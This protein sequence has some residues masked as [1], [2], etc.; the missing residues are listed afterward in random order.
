[1]IHLGIGVCCRIAVGY[2]GHQCTDVHI[3]ITRNISLVTTAIDIAGDVGT[4]NRSGVINN[5]I[6]RLTLHEFTIIVKDG[7]STCIHR[8]TVLIM[9]HDSNC[10]GRT[11][12]HR[13]RA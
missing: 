10:R 5:I 12:V 6:V 1:M 9:L 4:E 3:G 13:R 8:Y 11:N 7:D 2:R